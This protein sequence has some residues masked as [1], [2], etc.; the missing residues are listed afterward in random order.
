MS[1]VNR[2]F[3]AL[4]SVVVVIIGVFAML[5]L[6]QELIPQVDLPQVTV[7]A[8]APGASAEQVHERIADPLESSVQ[9][10]EDVE[11]TSTSAESG[12]AMVTIE[13]AYGTDVA[14]SANQ[15]DAQL[16]QL[17]DTF[18]EGTTTQV[19]SGGTSEIPAAVVSVSADLPT[20]E[21]AERLNTVVLTDV[22]DI[23][24]VAQAQVIGGPERIV[25]VT[26]D[27]D[28]LAENNLTESD[29]SD[30][31]GAV[32]LT[33]PSSPVAQDG[34][35]YDVTIGAE[36]ADLDDL[37]SI[38]VL[39][40]EPA[41]PGPEAQTPPEGGGVPGDGE[42][43]PE[44]G[45]MP[46]G[47]G[48]PTDPTGPESPEPPAPPEPVAL[49]EVAEVELTEREA[50]SVSRTNGQPSLTVMVVPTA[51]ANFV[52]VSTGLEEVM[53]D[54]VAEIG[55][56]ASYLVVFD[57]A[58]FIQESI[59]ALAQEGGLGLVM[60]VVVILLF[61]AAI[62]PTVVT[63]I[64]TPLSLL[65]TFVGLL[66]SGYTLNI[67]TLAAV[68]LSVGRV[69]DDSIVVIE[70]IKRHLGYGGDKRRR[71]VDAVGEVA[72]AITAATLATVIVFL[73]LGVVS[74]GAGELFRAF[75]LTVAIAMLAS[76][77]VAL[78]IVP[79]LAYW[80]LPVAAEEVRPTPEPEESA[81]ASDPKKN[82]A[83]RR[84]RWGRRRRRAPAE[85]ERTV[86]PAASPGPAPAPLVETDADRTWLT[87]AYRPVLRGTPRDR[88]SAVEGRAV[89]PV[90]A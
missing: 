61:L 58:P 69:V 47:P 7:I 27:E 8:T 80:F 12:L 46:G 28:A 72:G 9:T 41:A 53:D 64:S 26:P 50:T 70:N 51:T 87:A 76:L 37:R 85:A 31:M 65:M 23:T 24:G 11:R 18:P 74:G 14:R 22:E 38:P 67:L 66:V 63:A 10:V 36:V 73:P 57:Q 43:A 40:A 71:I 2:A 17:G 21:L 20:A 35:S 5:T 33:L 49:G 3:I 32:G 19:L 52:D 75:A 6:R 68:T 62:R 39:T 45:Q 34:T 77:L 55:G 89:G 25:E 82:A 42:M 54:A 88:K 4:A 90:R 84:R 13:L 15:V 44:E 56:D 79:V 29:L 48:A 30:A 86:Q 60:A 1:L 78:T 59:E 16:N 83:S 81:E